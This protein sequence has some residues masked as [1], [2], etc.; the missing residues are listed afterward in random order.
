MQTLTTRRNGNTCCTPTDPFNQIVSRLFADDFPSVAAVATPSAFPL[1][2]SEDETTVYVR[3][4]LP[5]FTKNDISLELKDGVL[6]IGAE[7]TEQSEQR[8]E[9]F[10][11]RERRTG[12]VSRRVQL[13]DVI[14]EDGADASFVDGVLTVS[15]PK[16]KPETPRTISI[17]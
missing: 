2:I 11:R 12:T 5:G 16:A 9:R 1:D 8:E 13:P 14:A 10:Y 6:T 17:S 4:N 3:A 15:I 7:H